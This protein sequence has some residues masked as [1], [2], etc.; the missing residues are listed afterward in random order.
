MLSKHTH[1]MLVQIRLWF[2]HIFYLKPRFTLND[3]FCCFIPQCTILLWRKEFYSNMMEI[4]VYL[5]IYKSHKDRICVTYDTCKEYIIRTT[6]YKVLQTLQIIF[7]M[8]LHK[9]LQ[10][11]TTK[12]LSSFLTI[13]MF[14]ILLHLHVWH[15]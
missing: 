10:I 3:M 6:L 13:P 14:V 5:I 1:I 4:Y 7:S 11:Q 8:K 2:D 12:L 9:N 15:A